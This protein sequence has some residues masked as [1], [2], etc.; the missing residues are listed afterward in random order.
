MSQEP[1]RYVGMHKVEVFAITEEVTSTTA[2]RELR[3]RYPGEGN[4]FTILPYWKA[5]LWFPQAVE[6]AE[7]AADERRQA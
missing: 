5:R 6:R 1:E 7:K 2:I 4:D 3:K